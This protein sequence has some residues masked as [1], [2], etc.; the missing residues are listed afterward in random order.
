MRT[1]RNSHRWRRGSSAI[2]FALL[3]PFFALIAIGA[4]DLGNAVQASMRLERA[5]RA[6]AQ[7][8]QV[9]PRDLAGIQSAVRAAWPAL[10]AADVPTPT[11]SCVCT[12]TV[13]ISEGATADCLAACAG[14]RVWTV[15][16][17]AQQSITP[18]ILNGLRSRS[19]SATVRV[20]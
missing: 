16:V 5:A 3:A 18:L 11:V 1:R 8:A 6:G 17:S 4:Y 19:G 13:R 12:G 10:G 15:T 14:A 7:Y 2:E 20:E 9:H